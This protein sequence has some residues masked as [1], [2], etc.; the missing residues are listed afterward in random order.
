[1]RMLSRAVN[2]V[3]LADRPRHILNVQKSRRVLRTIRMFRD[4][5]AAARSL[6]YLRH[7]D[8]L[9]FEEVVMSAL[10]DAGLLV[11]RNRRY[12]GDGGVDGAAWE[13]GDPTPKLV[14]ALSRNFRLHG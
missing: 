13:A 9:V 11:L 8:P 1:M 5:A 6:A 7:V 4:P 14:P 10:E 3:R 12:S 2:I